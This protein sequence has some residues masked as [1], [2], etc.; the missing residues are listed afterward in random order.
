MIDP[1]SRIY[2]KIQ[3]QNDWILQTQNKIIYSVDESPY[4]VDAPPKIAKCGFHCSYNF[5]QCFLFHL[6][7]QYNL[8]HY[9]YLRVRL[10]TEIDE[11]ESL[12]VV[13]GNEMV[14][15]EQLDLATVMKS[16]TEAMC[17]HTL[18]IGERISALDS[19]HRLASEIACV[20]YPKFLRFAI[21]HFIK[22]EE[23]SYLNAIAACPIIL[24]WIPE[25][26]KT[27]EMCLRAF[28][29]CEYALIYIP[30]KFI[31]KDIL[32]AGV[33][34]MNFVFYFPPFFKTYE[35]YKTHEEDLERLQAL[36]YPKKPVF[37][38]SIGDFNDISS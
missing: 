30:E 7:I 26:K 24:K 13:C 3:P 37:F 28:D 17:L 31:T 1:K 32:Y 23:A 10:G 5:M 6:P 34:R 38:E 35:I 21:E 29:A 19:S 27:E 12:G 11:D 2:C 22:P 4:A 33:Q 36:A 16:M 8:E 14:V 18:R 9:N 15:V 25:K 20:F